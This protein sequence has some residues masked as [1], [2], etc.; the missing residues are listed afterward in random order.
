[1]LTGVVMAQDDA[2]S[3]DRGIQ[4]DPTASFASQM[5]MEPS[6]VVGSDTQITGLMADCIK[7][8]E[9]S[10][11]ISPPVSL[12]NVEVPLPSQLPIVAPRPINPDDPGAIEPDFVLFRLS[13]P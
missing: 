10:L 11:M 9:V 7:P 8:D 3:F 6:L 12:R 4:T 13:F 2:A 5:S 1:M